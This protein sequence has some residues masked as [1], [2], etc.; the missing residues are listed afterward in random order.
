MDSL[1]APERPDAPTAPRPRA[2]PFSRRLTVWAVIFGVIVGASV[3]Q[4]LQG[5]LGLD[6]N[7]DT[8]LFGAFVLAVMTLLSCGFLAAVLCARTV[9][10]Q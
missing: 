7:G 2:W 4:R 3:S 10:R 6:G 9:R 5:P 1:D 8:L